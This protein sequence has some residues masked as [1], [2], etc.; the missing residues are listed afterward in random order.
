VYFRRIPKLLESEVGIHWEEGILMPE[1]ASWERLY[2]HW[3][4]I[5]EVLLAFSLVP[6]NQK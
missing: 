6:Q 1:G 5:A 4:A 2:Q 3:R